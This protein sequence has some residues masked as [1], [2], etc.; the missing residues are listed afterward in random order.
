MNKTYYRQRN[1]K[2][3]V[4]NFFG[5]LI[6]VLLVLAVI[7]LL[8]LYQYGTVETVTTVVKSK[9]WVN[10][11]ESSKYLVFTSGET[12]QNSD[13]IWHGKW[14][15]SDLYGSLEEGTKYRLTVYGWRIPFFSVYRN[16]IE[17]TPVTE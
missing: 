1:V 15:S 2:F 14:S 7:G 17:A 8:P 5:G 16:I 13:T 9:E 11:K 12:F 4:R 6:V 3:P 10:S